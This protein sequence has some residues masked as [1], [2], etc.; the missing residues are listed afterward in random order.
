MATRLSSLEQ[1]AQTLYHYDVVQGAWEQD[2]H[3][4]A[5]NI[6]HI[7]YHL[8]R[9]TTRKDFTDPAVV[10]GE[11]APD[12]LAYAIRLAR[13]SAVSLAQILPDAETEDIVAGVAGRFGSAPDHFVAWLNA[14][15]VLADAV[16]GLDHKS[17]FGPTAAELPR[18]STKAARLLLY[19][20]DLQASQH[21]FSLGESLEK[22]LDGLRQRFGIAVESD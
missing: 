17:E 6:G 21:N 9:D 13:Y 2:G 4:Q 18:Q 11:I 10:E 19:C 1:F 3:G 20:A 7:Q 22:R 8:A 16:H 15:S 5:A 14:S 12:G